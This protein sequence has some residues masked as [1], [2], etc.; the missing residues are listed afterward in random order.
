MEKSKAESWRNVFANWPQGF[1]RKGVLQPAF[2]ENIVFV[3]FL[4]SDDMLVLERSTPD[5]VG[6]RRVMVPFADI[7][8]LKFVE[9]L[10]TDQ[11]LKAGYSKGNTAGRPAASRS[12]AAPASATRP[13]TAAG[14]PSAP[15][16]QTPVGQPSSPTQ[17]PAIVQSPPAANTPSATPSN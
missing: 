16:A 5:N 13:A 4:I 10:K 6:A 9:P 2:D 14:P 8:A 11:F 3:D 17:N 15:A 7:A 1:K 12:S